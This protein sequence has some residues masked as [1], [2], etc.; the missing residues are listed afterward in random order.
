MKLQIENHQFLT[1]VALRLMIDQN[2]MIELFNTVGGCLLGADETACKSFDDYVKGK[3]EKAELDAD[4]ATV[5]DLFVVH[6][7]Y[8]KLSD[9]FVEA[10]GLVNS[11]HLSRMNDDPDFA[12]N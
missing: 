4:M 8:D 11:Y 10:F 6:Q 2:Y 9:V 7:A 12:V 5:G 3:I 1:E